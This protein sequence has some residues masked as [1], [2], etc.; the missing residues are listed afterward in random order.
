MAILIDL[1]GPIE[2]RLRAQLDDL[3]RKGKEAM[4]V[5]LYRQGLISHGELAES[6]GRSRYE[7]DGILKQ[8]KVTEDMVTSEDLAEQVEKL[9]KLVGP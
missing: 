9:S 2:D 3:D 4:L 8:Y 5:E 6:L 7:A 1:P